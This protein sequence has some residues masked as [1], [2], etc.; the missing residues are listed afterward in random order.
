MLAVRIERAVLADILEWC[1]QL[2]V[3]QARQRTLRKRLAA[4]ASGTLPI[5][6]ETPEEV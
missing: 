1:A 2:G 6:A 3:L 5:P 4:I